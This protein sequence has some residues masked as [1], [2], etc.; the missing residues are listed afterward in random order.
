M[1]FCKQISFQKSVC[2]I[3]LLGLT[4]GVIIE[5]MIS[6]VH[7]TSGYIYIPLASFASIFISGLIPVFLLILFIRHGRKTLVLIL[8]LVRAFVFGYTL[9]RVS[10]LYHGSGLLFQG[11]YFLSGSCCSF[12]VVYLLLCNDTL[13]QSSFSKLSRLAVLTSCIT[14]LMDYCLSVYFF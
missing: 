11:T 1:K 14:C 12:F 8:L 13:S 7:N 10:H 9:L 3:W 5:L 4:F 6:N 2:I